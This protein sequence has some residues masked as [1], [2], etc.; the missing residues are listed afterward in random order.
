MARRLLTRP[1][2]ILLTRLNHDV[3]AVNPDHIALVEAKPD[4]T[5]SLFGGD[6]LIVLESIDELI[7]RI[8]DYRRATRHDGDCPHLP[9]VAA[10]K[11]N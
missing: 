2:M 1:V 9:T 10:P 3:V 11:E 8:G 5:L 4:T 6:R 7:A